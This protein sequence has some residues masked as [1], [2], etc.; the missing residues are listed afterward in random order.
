[1]S[2]DRS[3]ASPFDIQFLLIEAVIYCATA[4]PVLHN[5]PWSVLPHWWPVFLGGPRRAESTKTLYNTRDSPILSVNCWLL[6]IRLFY[7]AIV[8]IDPF[9][10]YPSSYDGAKGDLSR[11]THTLSALDLSLDIFT[12][13][14]WEE[15]FLLLTFPLFFHFEMSGKKRTEKEAFY[16]WHFYLSEI[17]DAPITFSVKWN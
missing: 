17:V 14:W 12:R 2:Y 3:L 11:L 6:S 15:I 16:T 7:L 8:T 13:A 4:G 9:C 10:I 1:M 5:S